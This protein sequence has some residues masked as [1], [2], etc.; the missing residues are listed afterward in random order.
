M[1]FKKLLLTSTAC[2]ALVATLSSCGNG[3]VQLSYTDADGKVVTQN[4]AATK[5]A[6]EVSKSLDTIV[7]KN[8]EVTTSDVYS[9]TVSADLTIK[10]KLDEKD[11]DAKAKA[12]V[13][14]AG[15]VPALTETSTL[16]SVIKSASGYVGLSAEV[17][18][19]GALQ[20]TTQTTVDDL[21]KAEVELFLEGGTL[22]ADVQELKVPA[23]DSLSELG[24]EGSS[25]SMIASMLPMVEQ[26]IPALKGK[27]LKLDYE[28]L[29]GLVTMFG[30]TRI[31]T[32]AIDA[33]IQK[34]AKDQKDGKVKVCPMEILG[35]KVSREQLTTGIAKFVKEYNIEISKVSGN[36]VTF[37]ASL[38]LAKLASKAT[39]TTATTS[40]PISGV[41]EVELTINVIDLSYVG[42]KA[43]AKDIAVKN[44]KAD[45]KINGSVEIKA[46]KGG[47]IKKISDEKKTAAKDLMT[48]ITAAFTQP[49]ASQGN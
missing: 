25:T 13:T 21:N 28:T 17:S 49:A 39:T 3:S 11:L 1:N 16:E 10:G 14:V 8:Y 34:M 45:V 47:Q 22:Y 41:F 23:L 35:T 5:D 19:F 48:I 9:M 43:T 37:K 29:M 46:E 6:D 18:G 27:T 31:D 40:S 33:E 20:T 32:D 12:N 36:N 2:L 4:V 42:A 24:G 38:D 15:A 44:E 7:L 26:I 30:S